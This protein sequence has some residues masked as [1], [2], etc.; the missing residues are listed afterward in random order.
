VNYVPATIPRN[1]DG[2][3]NLTAPAPRTADGKPD[4]SGVWR[5]I[6]SKYTLNVAAD[7]NAGDI[8]PWAAASS[9]R[10][11]QNFNKDDLHARCLPPGPKIIF[12]TLFKIVQSPTV[13]V[14]LHEEA[15]SIFRQILMDGRQLPKD[16]NPSW[17]GYS[18]GGWE[19]DA[20]I[21]ETTGFNDKTTL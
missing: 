13:V 1:P 4:L 18:V 20:L 5:T 10:S 21:V 2:K 6:G 9:R 8:H 17:L 16:P 19:G 14:L 11:L 3:P 15:N 7:L 12:M